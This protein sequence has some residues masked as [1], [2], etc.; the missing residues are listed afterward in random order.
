[1][2]TATCTQCGLEKA[3]DEFNKRSRK[4]NGR[5]SQCKECSRAQ[6]LMGSF[7]LSLDEYDLM[8]EQQGGCCKICGTDSPGH[9]GRFIVDHNH[10]TGQIR[11]LLCNS[12]NVGIGHLKD[13][14]TILQSALNYLSENGYYGT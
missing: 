13:N 10:L 3:L 6:R 8:L 2:K 7:G 5:Q 11:G 1:M 4:A 14:P 12:C 9:K